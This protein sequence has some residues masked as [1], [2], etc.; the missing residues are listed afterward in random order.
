MPNAQVVAD[1]FHVMKQVNDELDRQ[2]KQEKRQAETE[3]NKQYASEIIANLNK[4]KYVLLKNQES[5]TELQLLKL[6]KVKLASPKLGLM[7]ELQEEFRN[8]FEKNNDWLSGLFSLGKW[9][10][11]AA[12]YF[13]SSQKTIKRWLDEIVAYFDNR[14]TSG[15]VEGINNQLKLIK[16]SAYGFR[17]F[18]NFRVRCLLCWHFNC[19][20]SILGTEEPKQFAFPSLK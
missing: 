17:N 19:Y 16:R 15:V 11:S 8:I 12:Q 4:S 5:L 3:N 1:R 10:N 20:F 6:G 13:P 9:L 14:T 2:R 7:H 18:D